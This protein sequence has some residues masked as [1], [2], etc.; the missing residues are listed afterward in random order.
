MTKQTH[1]LLFSGPT[2]QRG[3]AF[4]ISMVMLLILSLSAITAMRVSNSELTMA[5]AVENQNEA[6]VAAE[7]SL[8]AGERE[9]ASKFDGAPA[10]DFEQS[11]DGFYSQGTFTM[12]SPDWNG[13]AYETD[14]NGAQYVVEYLGTAPPPRGSLAL[15]AG[16]ATAQLFVYRIVGRGNSSRGSVRINETI[17][18][19]SE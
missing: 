13:I 11:G 3:A 5:N 4:V 16:A 12:N 15:G 19:T 2:R 17:F 14:A 1:R 7:N 10:F 9:V 6:F 8:R 18:A